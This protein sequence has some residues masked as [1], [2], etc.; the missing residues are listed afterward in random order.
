ME[1]PLGKFYLC[2]RALFVVE[3]PLTAAQCDDIL[4]S[5][6]YAQLAA[7]KK[8]SIFTEHSQWSTFYEGVLKGLGSVPFN[9]WT[10]SLADNQDD[11]FSVPELLGSA[12]RYNPED[13]RRVINRLGTRAEALNDFT[14]ALCQSLPDE[15]LMPGEQVPLQSVV[16]VQVASVSA[17]GVMAWASIN[18]RTTQPL[19]GDLFHQRFTWQGLTSPIETRY[20]ETHSSERVFSKLR[21]TVLSRVSTRKPL[22][23]KELL[24]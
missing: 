2:H 23:I 7:D 24:L 14:Q 5:C 6:L 20:F 21:S 17:V 19:S 16:S 13:T 22:L 4:C 10:R 11:D 15:A 1:N 9:H 8:H 3:V 18:F 12:L